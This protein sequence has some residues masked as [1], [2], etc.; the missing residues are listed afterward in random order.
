MDLS[1]FPVA[2]SL[3]LST[4][5]WVL[6]FWFGLQLL[7]LN[8]KTR[9]LEFA[10]ADLEERLLSEIKKR[11]GSLG[12]KARKDEEELIEKLKQTPPQPSGPWWMDL[13]HPDLKH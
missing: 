5:A 12:V 6:C 10:I 8:R 3:V 11:A 7:S 1:W 13:V 9:V 4:G 2:V